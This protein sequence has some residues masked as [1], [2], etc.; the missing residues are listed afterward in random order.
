MAN[1][2]RRNM[3][4]LGEEMAPELEPQDIELIDETFEGY[5]D[6]TGGGVTEGGNLAEVMSEDDLELLSGDLMAAI[7][8][9][10]DSLD[11]WRR[12]IKDGLDVLGLASE[13][14]DTS[15]DGA[16]NVSHPLLLESVVKYQAKARAQLLPPGG[17]VKTRIIGTST[18]ELRAAAR[19]KSEYMNFLVQEEMHEYEPEHD[20]ML[21]YQ[22]FLGSGITKTFF[23]PNLGRE[24]SR[25]VS[26]NNFIV[27]YYAS[28]FETAPRLT[29]VFTLTD[30]DLQERM[31]LGAYREVE[32]DQG[33]PVTKFDELNS[34]IDKLI[35]RSRPVDGNVHNMVECHVKLRVNPENG[36]YE[37]DEY[38]D[39]HNYVVTIHMDSGKVLSVYLNEDENGNK[40]SYYTH[41]PFIPGFGIYGFGYLHLVGGLSE[42]STKI[43][44]QLINAG[45]FS[46]FPAGF[47]AHGIRVTGTAEPLMPGEWRDVHTLG[48]DLQR[49]LV[50]LPYKEPS[51]TLV[52]LLEIVVGS[53]Q[54][55]ADS[56]EEVVNNA[57][58]YGPVNTTLALMEASGQLFNGIH[59]R[60]FRSQKNE[61]KIL[62]RLIRESD[63]KEYPYNVDP[64]QPSI[65]TQDF[66]AAISTIP[67][68]DPRMPSEAHRLA[69]AMSHFQIAVQAPDQHNMPAILTDLHRAIG[70]D[71]AERYVKSVTPPPPMDPVT[72]NAAILSGSPAK[73]YPGQN[74]EAHLFLHIHGLLNNPLY[75]QNKQVAATAEAHIQEHLGLKFKADVERA[76]GQQ[77]PQVDPNDPNA[78]EMQNQI[79]MA[80]AQQVEAIVQMNTMEAMDMVRRQITLDPALE[81][82]M[83]KVANDGKKITVEQMKAITAAMNDMMKHRDIER[84]NWDEYRTDTRIRQ[85]ELDIDW[86]E[87]D[88]KRKQ[89][90][91]SNSNS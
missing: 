76:I 32:I 88:I 91:K 66:A 74:H 81:I 62:E 80:A 71:A 3:I 65:F 45:I 23:D 90:N 86:A 44:R 77:I 2:E 78:M 64:A 47:K 89:A 53:G 87:V 29:E 13:D 79:A 34:A 60:L 43:M 85:E 83:Q 55:F 39:C 31:R 11:E 59:E 12:I 33:T 7:E 17:P 50:P 57:K 4:P 75:G 21:F 37:P 26:A 28:D 6:E 35:G 9:D 48:Q 30:N 49:S 63:R 22:G 36:E 46:N 84:R 8:S 1:V 61:F 25:N 67:A 51:P 5:D 82:E 18:E 19:R 73:A 58:N 52:K 69:R 72:E 38:E 20:R 42:T 56:V 15:F 68:S 41:W 14:E 70:E 27:D 10:Y 24:S 16:S 54:R 40:Y